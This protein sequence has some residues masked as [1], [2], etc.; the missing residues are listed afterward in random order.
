M[1]DGDA[2]LELVQPLLGGRA[3]AAFVGTERALVRDYEVEIASRS[4]AGNPVIGVARSGLWLATTAH[5]QGG[6]WHVTGSWSLAAHDEPRLHVHAET[7]PL[8]L[9]VP[10]YRTTT[11]PWDA[12]MPL[13]L[14]HVLGQGPAWT[15]NGAPTQVTVRLTRR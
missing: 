11:L 7:Q 9:H 14:D 15:T 4:T 3:T 1:R 2:P 10:D 6:S 12:T 5:E 13:D 8:L